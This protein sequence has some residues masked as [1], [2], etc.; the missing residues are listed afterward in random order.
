MSVKSMFEFR[1]PEAAREEGLRLA[2]AV[3]NDMVPLE[4][5]LDHEVIQDL[6]DPGHL[7]V[8]TRWATRT[9]ANAVLAG[10]K[11]D[12]KI[13]RITELLPDRPAGFVGDVLTPARIASH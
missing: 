3:G 12:P 5:Y 9:H 7:M 1:F 6:S 2:T 13:K 8:N 4:G 10:Y 11:N